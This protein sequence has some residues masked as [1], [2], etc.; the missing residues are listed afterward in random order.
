MS[1]RLTVGERRRRRAARSRP[2]TRPRRAASFASVGIRQLAPAD[3]GGGHDEQRP[4]GSSRPESRLVGFRAVRR[5]WQR[6]RRVAADVRERAARGHVCLPTPRRRAAAQDQS[7]TAATSARRASANCGDL[8]CACAAARDPPPGTRPD[9]PAARAGAVER[10]VASRRASACCVSPEMRMRER[11]STAVRGRLAYRSAGSFARQRHTIVFHFRRHMF[12]RA[13]RSLAIAINVSGTLSAMKRQAPA[14]HFVQRHAERPDIGAV[15]DRPAHRL[16][17]RHIGRST[18]RDSGERQLD[19]DWRIWQDRNR[20][21]SRPAGDHDVGRLDIPVDDSFGMRRG[22]PRAICMP[23]ST[24]CPAGRR[25]RR[26]L[27]VQVVAFV[28]AITI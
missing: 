25:P 24:A 15:I 8:T 13:R 26:I 14:E 27:A 2:T 11:S 3:L 20:G 6:V 17:R 19:R 10:L 16:F 1:I 9:R 28:Q 21:A 12:E 5:R 7:R 4:P 22:N 23:I 18:D